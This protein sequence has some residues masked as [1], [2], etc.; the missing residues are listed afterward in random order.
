ME[1]FSLL[2]ALSR[3]A[4]NILQLH[5]LCDLLHFCSIVYGRIRLL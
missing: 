1:Y 2:S 5:K 4:Q 3:S